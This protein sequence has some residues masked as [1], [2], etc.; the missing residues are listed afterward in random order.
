MK[1]SWENPWT[2]ISS[3]KDPWVKISN[4][5]RPI[6][7]GFDDQG[8]LNPATEITENEGSSRR[9]DFLNV[10]KKP[11]LPVSGNNHNAPENSTD[12]GE[13]SNQKNN[14]FNDTNQVSSFET[15]SKIAYNR[16]AMIILIL[17]EVLAESPINMQTF[18]GITP[19]D[20]AST[21]ALYLLMSDSKKREYHKA[22]LHPRTTHR[23]LLTAQS[24]PHNLSNLQPCSHTPT[25]WTCLLGIKFYSKGNTDPQN[26]HQ[27]DSGTE[28]ELS[29]QT[30]PWTSLPQERNESL[31]EEIRAIRSFW[32]KSSS[33]WSRERRIT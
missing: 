12:Q 11:F 17:D 19:E 18:R 33:I 20:M 16:D 32:R 22:A 13:A 29:T 8:S 28:R 4:R 9:L 23:S 15:Y 26:H 10:L 24:R 30:C 5:D 14:T 25:H 1:T 6:P 31:K 27:P 3:W 7:M 2:K 21:K